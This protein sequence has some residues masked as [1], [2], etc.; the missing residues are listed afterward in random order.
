MS[1]RRITGPG[2]RYSLVHSW[3]VG[4]NM[5][6]FRRHFRFA[7][8]EGGPGGAAGSAGLWPSGA[9][10]EEL[11]WQPEEFSLPEVLPAGI[12]RKTGRKNSNLRYQGLGKVGT[13]S[14]LDK[15][16]MVLH[17]KR[18]L[19]LAGQ[20]QGGYTEHDLRFRL[21]YEEPKY[22]ER[23]VLLALLDVSGSMEE[24]AKQIARLFYWH[25]LSLTER[26]F[27][28]VEPVFIIHHTEAVEVSRGRFFT[29]SS[30]G[31]TKFSPV[32]RLAWEIIN[33]RY[34]QDPSPVALFHLS[35]GYNIAHDQKE[36][37]SWL[38]KLCQVCRLVC[39][40][41]VGGRQQNLKTYGDSFQEWSHPALMHFQ[42][43]DQT[44]VSSALN[45]LL[46]QILAHME[47]D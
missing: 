32:Y 3:Q 11:R 42:I 4:Q 6:L 17:R 43:E 2:F 28:Q 20:Q 37:Q 7:K 15:K 13:C 29:K 36:S 21:W 24:D 16:A 19:R 35:D 40:G 39:Y 8:V 10:E 45:A 25:L 5:E 18:R 12:R 34:L 46:P 44:Q 22:P 38:M 30:G 27:W 31:G 14:Q 33:A 23:L 1:S 26:I 41:E 9:D 47:R